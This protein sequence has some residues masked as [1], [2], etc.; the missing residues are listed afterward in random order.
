M[1]L[2]ALGNCASGAACRGDPYLGRG[3]S[4]VRAAFVLPRIGA[5]DDRRDANLAL[6]FALHT[7][8]A[9]TQRAGW[10]PID[11]EVPLLDSLRPVSLLIAVAACVMTFGLRWSIFR[12][13]GACAAMGLAAQL[14]GLT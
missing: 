13:L 5:L 1:K 6:Y 10:G 12:T 3:P 8:F 11:L 7:L 14:T 4:R 2:G 9:D